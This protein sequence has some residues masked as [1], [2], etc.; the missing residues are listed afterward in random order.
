MSDSSKASP[1]CAACGDSIEPPVTAYNAS[2]APV[3][4]DCLADAVAEV[5]DALGLYADE[6]FES[7]DGEEGAT[8]AD[9]SPTS[10]QPDSGAQ[11]TRSQGDEDTWPKRFA[12]GEPIPDALRDNEAVHLAETQ[13]IKQADDGPG[14]EPTIVAHHEEHSPSTWIRVDGAALDDLSSA[15]KYSANE[16]VLSALEPDAGV[17]RAAWYSDE[18]VSAPAIG[19]TDEEM[20][21]GAKLTPADVA[22]A[23]KV[24]EHLREDMMIGEARTMNEAHALLQE[25]SPADTPFT[26][27]N[28]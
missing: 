19:D 2:D 25:H 27:D 16:A 28:E 20:E 1:V 17:W 23:F 14:Q 12:P 13:P 18:E 10:D 8:S 4:E 22:S 11:A 15:A 9:G 7:A 26:T 3:H 5:N 6:M 24:L 21:Q